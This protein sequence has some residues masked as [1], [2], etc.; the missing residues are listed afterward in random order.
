MNTAE[1]TIAEWEEISRSHYV[2]TEFIM[3]FLEEIIEKSDTQAPL[4]SRRIK[5]TCEHCEKE[6]TDK[7]N[8]KRHMKM[9]AVNKEFPCS[10]CSRKFYRQDKKKMH[11]KNCRRL[12]ISTEDRGRDMPI[13]RNTLRKN[14]SFF[15]RKVV[16]WSKLKH[17]RKLCCS[18]VSSK[19][20]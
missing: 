5:H 7:R 18:S 14:I 11:E 2:S 3:E 1:L 6:F 9:H 17:V 20:L 10:F 4:S 12:Q 16:N 8:L 19:Q 15:C 13:E